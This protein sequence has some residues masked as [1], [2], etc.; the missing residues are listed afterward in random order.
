MTTW[1]RVA[2]DTG[3]TIDVTVLGITD[4]TTASAWEAHVWITGTTATTLSASATSATVV[5][6]NLGSWLTS[7]TPG[8]YN[9]ELQAT[10]AGNPRTW[11][12]GTPDQI[13]VRA[14]GA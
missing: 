4:A 10:V 8:L 12:E 9:L 11:P 6:V 3:D 7:A 1:N 5:R 14:Q 2:G 13:V